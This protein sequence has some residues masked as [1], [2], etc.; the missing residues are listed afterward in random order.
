MDANAGVFEA[1][2]GQEDVI[3]ADRLIHASLVD[4]IRLCSASATPSSTWT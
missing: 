4:G 2:L 1:V 3:I